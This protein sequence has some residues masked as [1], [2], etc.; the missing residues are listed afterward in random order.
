MKR[1]LFTFLF[2]VL[3]ITVFS[4]K[5]LDSPWEILIKRG[6]AL[7][8]EP[9][10]NPYRTFNKDKQSLDCK[11]QFK[12]GTNFAFYGS[13]F[14]DKKTHW[15]KVLR[16]QTNEWTG[17][18]D[19]VSIGWRNY[20]VNRNDPENLQV[21]LYAHRNHW[22]NN[23]GRIAVYLTNIDQY[24][25]Y[26]VNM[27]LSEQFTYLN[28]NGYGAITIYDVNSWGGVFDHLE[29]RMMA[30]CG[31][32]GIWN[33]NW[34]RAPENIHFNVIDAYADYS[35]FWV[36]G[37]PEYKADRKLKFVLCR[38]NKN[39]EYRDYWSNSIS[40]SHPSDYSTNTE[41]YTNEEPDLELQSNSSF[42]IIEGNSPPMNF[43]A[44][45][46]ILNPNTIIEKGTEVYFGPQ[47][48]KS[49]RIENVLLS[50]EINNDYITDTVEY[51]IPII[52]KDIN[53]YNTNMLKNDLLVYPQP[54]KDVLYF[55][56]PSIETQKIQIFDTR[57]FSVYVEYNVILNHYKLDLSFLK[58]GIYFY[59]II[60]TDN[61]EFKGKIIKQ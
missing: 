34:E 19:Y 24:V 36:Y 12:G 59:K 41:Q 45:E 61:I 11:I 55:H 13:L 6:Y 52:E 37:Y 32:I 7:A 20:K 44:N 31:E 46:I 30:Q 5:V 48:L 18:R 26:E 35:G 23:P 2:L 17:K 21:A 50:S 10:I 53:E 1:H 56:N 4:Q 38:I 58:S 25:S 27:C 42:F 22:E 49:Y 29:T 40:L 39:F 15:Q 16:I 43:Y 3:Y 14:D 33:P 51:D 28:F 54:T 57:G 9:L 8:D 60:T 47:N